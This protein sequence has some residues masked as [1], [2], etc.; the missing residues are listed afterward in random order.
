M[1]DVAKAN[2]TQPRDWTPSRDEME[3]ATCN[4]PYPPAQPVAGGLV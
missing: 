2:T 4:E 1:N 3:R